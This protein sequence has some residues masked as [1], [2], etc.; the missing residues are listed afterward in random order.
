VRARL[1]R[2]I[3]AARQVDRDD[4]EAA[5]AFDELKAYWDLGRWVEIVL[6]DSRAAREVLRRAV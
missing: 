5:A 2:K 3:E 6:G 1:G 4:V